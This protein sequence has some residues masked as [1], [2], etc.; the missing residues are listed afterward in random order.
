M[1]HSSNIRQAGYQ[2]TGLSQAAAAPAAALNS[3]TVVVVADELGM[4]LNILYY[5]LLSV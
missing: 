4:V 1:T 5:I 2:E 3:E